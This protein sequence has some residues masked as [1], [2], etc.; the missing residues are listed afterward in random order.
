MVDLVTHPHA[1]YLRAHG[2]NAGGYVRG[3][4]V[5][6][7]FDYIYPKKE[8]KEIAARAV[9]GAEGG[10][11]GH[12]VYKKNKEDYAPKAALMFRNLIEKDHPELVAPQ[13]EREELTY[14]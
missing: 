11:E 13:R 7:R 5:P 4:S 8:L 10:D 9:E 3:R 1:A 2:R 6:E 12:V 14:A